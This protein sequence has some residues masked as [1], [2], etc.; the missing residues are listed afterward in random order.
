[1]MKLTVTEIAIHRETENPVFGKDVIYVRLVDE[2]AGPFLNI[3]Q[4]TES[5]AYNEIRIDFT[6]FET[7]IEAVNKLKESANYDY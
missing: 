7:L 3:Y 1:M 2:G 6:E 5:G 4:E